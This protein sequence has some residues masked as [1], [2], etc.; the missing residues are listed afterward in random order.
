[1]GAFCIINSMGRRKK[2]G[3]KAKESQGQQGGCCE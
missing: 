3:N 1:M 2:V